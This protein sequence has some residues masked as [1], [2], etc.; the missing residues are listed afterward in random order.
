MP[1]PSADAVF[2]ARCGKD[3]NVA[4]DLCRGHSGDAGTK[5]QPPDPVIPRQPAINRVHTVRPI[6]ADRMLQPAKGRASR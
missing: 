1:P 2:R 4:A 3:V 5:G 6:D